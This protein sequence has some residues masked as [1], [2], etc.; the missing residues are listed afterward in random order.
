MSGSVPDL[1]DI[2]AFVA[3][4]RAGGMSPASA[5][6]GAPRSTLSRSLGRLEAALGV[7]LARRSPRAFSLTDEGHRYYEEV[8]GAV[9]RLSTSHDAV[10]PGSEER[11]IRVS[12]PIL[13]SHYFMPPALAAFREAFPT[14]SVRLRVEEERVDMDA[15]GID[16]VVRAGDPGGQAHVGRELFRSHR[17]LYA[18]PG[19]LDR[20]GAPEAPDDLASHDLIGCVPL[21]RIDEGVTWHLQADRRG[22]QIAVRPFLAVNDPEAGADLACRNMGLSLLPQFVALP[23]VRSGALRRV[24]PN[25]QEDARPVRALFADGRKA[26]DAVRGLARAM[27]DCAPDVVGP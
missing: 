16:M 4:V 21:P 26:S 10:S 8:R 13:V 3:I 15:L 14:T 20:R 23:Y 27:A 17:R 12:V 5:R 22:A 25:W 19:Y 11:T 6:S 9:E 7:T 1:N 2:A 18:A 24:L